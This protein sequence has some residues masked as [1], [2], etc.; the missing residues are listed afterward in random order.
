M[1]RLVFTLAA[2]A[3][4]CHVSTAR[5]ANPGVSW[6]GAN[7]SWNGGGIGIAAAAIDDPASEEG[8]ALLSVSIEKDGSLSGEWKRLK[9]FFGPMDRQA[10]MAITA[11]EKSLKAQVMA[12]N[13][14]VGLDNLAV[15]AK[16]WQGNEAAVKVVRSDAASTD[17]KPVKTIDSLVF[18]DADGATLAS[19]SNGKLSLAGWDY[20]AKG[21]LF[22]ANLGGELSYLPLEDGGGGCGCTNAWASLAGWIG[23]GTAVGTNGLD[24]VDKTLFE[25]VTHAGFISDV[26]DLSIGRTYVE[27]V[28]RDRISIKGFAEGE[29]CDAS[30]TAMLADPSVADAGRHLVLTRY[31]TRDGFPAFLHYL[32]IGDIALT[33]KPD[34]SSVTTNKANGASADG[35]LS[36]Y[37]WTNAADGKVPV[38]RSGGLSWEDAGTPP[39]GVTL[40]DVEKTDG[41]KAMAVSGFAAAGANTMP[42]KTDSGTLAWGAPFGTNTV[43]LAGAGINVTANGEGAVTISAQGLSDG[44]SSSG[45][46][47]QAASYQLN[48]VT[49]VRYDATTH[50]FQKKVLTVTIYGEVGDDGGWLDVFEAVSHSAE[51]GGGVSE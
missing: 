20:G 14:A 48:V 25:T 2:L 32:P 3:A 45:G 24:F 11:L 28:D 43:I 38:K 49:D 4:I 1:R 26:D 10:W 37:G 29:A 39:D 15:V 47:I 18:P 51:H 36:L 41:T 42:Y 27:S 44:G 19:A 23:D 16:D 40:V 21:P 33:A 30:L 46:G 5:A 8:F 9:E 35:S 50:K 6:Y 12:E 17:G 22:L 31:Q 7:S 34:E 13:I